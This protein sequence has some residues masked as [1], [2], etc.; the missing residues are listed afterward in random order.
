M[1]TTWD[2]TGNCR[3]VLFVGSKRCHEAVIVNPEPILGL[4]LISLSLETL[5]ESLLQ[6]QLLLAHNMSHTVQAQQ[7]AK[8]RLSNEAEIFQSLNPI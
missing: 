8:K 3:K 2:R 5:Q 4:L 7:A 6:G 1:K